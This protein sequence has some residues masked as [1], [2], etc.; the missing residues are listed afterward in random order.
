[1][2]ILYCIISFV[3]IIALLIYFKVIDIRIADSKS[4]DRFKI[5]VVNNSYISTLKAFITPE[6]YE[7]IIGK[8][9]FFTTWNS[10][11]RG[12]IEGIPVLNQI[13][14]KYADSNK[15][16]FLAYCSDL[17]TSSIAAFLESRKLHMDFRFLTAE[18][19]LRSSLRTILSSNPG[20]GPIDPTL[21][22]LNMSFIIDAQEKVLYYKG[23]GLMKKDLPLIFPILDK[24]ENFDGVVIKKTAST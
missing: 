15:I 9:I 22:G 23:G 1:M 21:D 12:S 10:F 5:N 8:V 14:M 20:L 18:E 6:D 24:V 16:V 11:C 4:Q 17:K 2:I 19:G 13:Q 3:L 7:H